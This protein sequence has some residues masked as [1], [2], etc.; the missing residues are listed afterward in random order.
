MPRDGTTEMISLAVGGRDD[1][2]GAPGAGG[3]G[4]WRAR[5]GCGSPSRAAGL[6]IHDYDVVA[7]TV[8]WDD[9][10]R[11]LWGVGPD[12]PITYDVFMAGVHPE[13]RAAVQAEVER[14]LDPAG[15]A[16]S[17]PSIGSSE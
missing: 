15:P 5:S 13:D 9:R 1:G 7:G 10:V 11:E 3:R 2:G 12:L 8:Q 6:G 17:T 4:C 14:A 16:S